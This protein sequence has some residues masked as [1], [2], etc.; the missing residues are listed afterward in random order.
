MRFI[1]VLLTFLIPT[2]SFSQTDPYGYVNGYWSYFIPDT[3]DIVLFKAPQYFS[4]PNVVKQNQSDLDFYGME[5]KTEFSF[6]EYILTATTYIAVSDINNK[7]DYS[8]L[9]NDHLSM[10]Q[11]TY[12][13]MKSPN[14]IKVYWSGYNRNG[15]PI[16]GSKVFSVSNWIIR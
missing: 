12:G 8:W 5:V 10:H 15:T 4:F 7:F 13:K 1:L 3:S 16:S 11:G 9:I 14:R 2:M 6:G